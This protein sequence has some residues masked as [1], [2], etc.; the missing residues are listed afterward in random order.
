[1]T[2]PVTHFEIFAEEPAKLADFY[3]ELFDWKITKAP[4]LDYF[5][6]Q[7]APPEVPAIRGGITYR[8]IAE[9]RSW[10][11]LRVGPVAR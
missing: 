8:A 9:P 4:G 6:I 10:V 1:M 3:R 11:P 7:V 5:H 2:A